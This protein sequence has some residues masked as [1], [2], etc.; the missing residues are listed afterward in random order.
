MRLVLAMLGLVLVPLAAQA[1][2]TPEQ[3]QAFADRTATLILAIDASRRCPGLDTV[4]RAVAEKLYELDRGDL[5]K[6]N[7]GA[8]AALDGA[9]AQFAGKACNDPQLLGVRNEGEAY[10]RIVTGSAALVLRELPKCDAAAY[11][12]RAKIWAS[13][14]KVPAALERHVAQLAAPLRAWASARCSGMV[15][16][17][18]VLSIAGAAVAAGE[19]WRERGFSECVTVGGLQSWRPVCAWKAPGPAGLVAGKICDLSS[20]FFKREKCAFGFDAAGNLLLTYAWSIDS[21]SQDPVSEVAL[22]IGGT[23]HATSQVQNEAGQRRTWRFPAAAAQALLKA[24]R[25]AKVE[26]EAV[27]AGV[28]AT[29]NVSQPAGDFQDAV[30]LAKALRGG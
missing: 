27:M 19:L 17:Q 7:S 6:L 18:A 5:I 16:G 21:D 13:A 11:F 8:G 26:D 20:G 30:L 3:V 29:T 2:P 25:D 24:A 14:Y 15:D 28:T 1:Q 10:A 4:E 9:R 23:R 22:V 12:P